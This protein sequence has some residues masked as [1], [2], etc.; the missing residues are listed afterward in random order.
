M[1]FEHRLTV[2]LQGLGLIEKKFPVVIGN[3]YATT[4]E[5]SDYFG[6]GC[7]PSLSEITVKSVEEKL[8]HHMESQALGTP[9]VP[10]R[11]VKSV[12]DAITAWKGAFIVGPADWRVRLVF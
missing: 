4:T 8:R 12:V 3:F 5:Y 6:S 7:H 2:E 1:F 9:I 11:T 10:N